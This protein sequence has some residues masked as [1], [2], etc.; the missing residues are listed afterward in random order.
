MAIKERILFVVSNFEAQIEYENIDFTAVKVKQYDAVKKA[1]NSGSLKMSSLSL[2][3]SLSS[4]EICSQRQLSLQFH[5]FVGCY[6]PKKL[7]IECRQ[8]TKLREKQ[9]AYFLL[10][11][12]R[13]FA[14]NWF[15]WDSSHAIWYLA[16]RLIISAPAEVSHVIATKFQP[17]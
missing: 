16:P 1:M 8:N 5:H 17:G 2:Q 6:H 14:C 13:L 3:I 7:E 15:Y 12:L 9:C 4:W 10:I 11:L